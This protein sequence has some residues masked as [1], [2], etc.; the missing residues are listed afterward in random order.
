[1]KVQKLVVQIIIVLTFAILVGIASAQ[2]KTTGSSDYIEFEALKV[3]QEWASLVSQADVAGLQKL[4]SDNYIHIHGTG[5]VESKA[6]FIEALKN[7]SRKYDT[8][9]F[10]EVSVRVFGSSAVVMGKYNLKAFARGK[11]LEGVSR[12]GLILVKIQNEQKVVSFQA[13]S[14][15]QLKENNTA[16][17]TNEK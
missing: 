2:E 1:M 14:I 13:T 5:L 17:T 9:K 12:F 8:I 4:L 11:A 15:P 10:E 7:G 3:A 6:Q 16:R